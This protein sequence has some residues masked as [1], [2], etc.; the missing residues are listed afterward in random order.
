MKMYFSTLRPVGPGTFP[1]EGMIEFENYNSRLYVPAINRA[2]WGV[3]YY[4]RELTREEMENYD[5]V[6]FS[7]E[8]EN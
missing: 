6:P 5:L 7:E 1:K 3:L 8:L 4:N 2:A